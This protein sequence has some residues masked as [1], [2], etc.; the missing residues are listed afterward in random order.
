MSPTCPLS[1]VRNTEV[2]K[3]APSIEMLRARVVAAV[4][5]AV[6]TV[7]RL[8]SAQEVSFRCAEREVRDVVLALG[9]ALVVLFLGLREQHVMA[10]HRAAHGTR[11][12]GMFRTLR[13]APPIARNLTTLFGV[14]RYFRCYLREVAKADRHGMHPLDVS[15][16][17]GRDRISWNVLTLA[18]RLATKMAFAEARTTLGTFVPD[19]PSTEVI[20]KTVLGLGRHTAAFVEQAPAPEGDG[21]VLII[22]F[23]GKGAPTATARE[24]AR[25][26]RKRGHHKPCRS[27]RHRGRQRRSRHP[28]QPRRKKGDKAK[29]ARMATM[30]VMYT[31]RRV[32]TR[33]LEGPITV[34]LYASFANK[35]HA[36]ELARRWADKRGFAD[37]SGKLVQVLSYGDLD[38]RNLCAQYFPKAEHTVDFYHVLERVHD[39]GKCLMREG[40]KQLAAWFDD[41]REQ[42]LGDRAEFIVEELRQ[43][44]LAIARTGPGNKGRRKRLEDAMLYIE[45]RLPNIRYG[46]LRRRDLEIGTGAVEG[47]VKRI[48]GQRC[49]HGGMRWIRERV[50]AIVQLRCIEVNGQ[51]HDFEAFVHRRMHERSLALDRAQ[52]LQTS[53]PTPLPEAA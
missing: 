33:R 38:L 44:L 14:V 53:T 9:R 11:Y 25:R 22:Q 36:F 21:E 2:E 48:I 17:L 13:Q 51:W 18:A 37:G 32:G 34:R 39:A 27:A 5:A 50:E 6:G 40:S 24:L 23:D 4:D 20:E 19:A 47:A 7:E 31:L 1:L 43:R 42:L 10:A 29:N 45:R 12:Q 15:L 41:K 28:R 26:R 30:V 16:G 52:R 3:S 8:S 46:S 35:R 49:D